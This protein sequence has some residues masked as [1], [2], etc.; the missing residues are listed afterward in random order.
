MRIAD[1][2]LI[3]LSHQHEDHVGL[4]ASVR[5]RSG[6]EV[7]AHELLAGLLRDVSA[8]RDAEDA[9][10]EAMLALHGAPRDVI[11]TVAEVS[12]VAREFIESVEVTRVLETAT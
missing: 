12:P 1:L 8:E 9:Y 6:C 11:A 10:E 2:E 4:A 5:E 7:A 3:V